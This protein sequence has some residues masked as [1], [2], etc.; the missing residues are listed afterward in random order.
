MIDINS[1][2]NVSFDW[3]GGEH[4]YP[5]FGNMLVSSHPKFLAI[6]EIRGHNEDNIMS[7]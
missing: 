5:D 2:F 1:S 7:I 6:H 4:Y 3:A